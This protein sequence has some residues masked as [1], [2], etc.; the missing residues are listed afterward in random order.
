MRSGIALSVVLAA[1]VCVLLMIAGQSGPTQAQSKKLDPELVGRIFK[2]IAGDKDAIEIAEMPPLRGKE[3]M[4]LF[5]FENGITNG[6]LNQEQFLRYLEQLDELRKKTAKDPRKLAQ[7]VQAREERAAN[8]F[9]RLDLNSDNV[10]N[11][12]EIAKSKASF[13][14][15][16]DEWK[17]WDR[18][19]D[20]LIDMT[21]FKAFYLDF[22]K[23]R[24]DAREKA[25]AKDKD[26]KEPPARSILIEEDDIDPPVVYHYGKK[27]PP[28]LPKWFVEL[29]KNRDGQVS[30][31]EWR[32][33]GRDVAE[34]VKMDRND[35]GILTVEEVLWHARKPA[36]L[37]PTGPTRFE[38][39]IDATAGERYRDKRLFK[40]FPI[41]LE[42]GKTYQ[43]DL[44]SKDFDAYLYLENAAGALLAQ[45]D[46]SGG[47]LNARIVH[48]VT[49]SGA[50]RVIATSINGNKTG[51]FKLSIRVVGETGGGGAAKGV[52][53]WFKAL[54]KN[55]DGQVSLYEW[56]MGGRDVAEFALVDRND[57]GL[58]TAEEIL[59]YL[60]RPLEVGP[61][62]LAQLEGN[63]DE[64]REERYRNKKSFKVFTLRLEEGKTYQIDLISKSFQ[65]FIHLEDAEGNVIMEVGASNIGA[66]ARMLF[67]A[68]RTGTYKII[69][70]SLA[71]HRTGPFSLTIKER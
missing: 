8:L 19:G 43:I 22:H 62:G 26:K 58:I 53:P 71:G 16:H 59:L 60:K 56:R 33:G 17:K 66:N 54:D 14:T 44:V 68:D 31:Y 61:T 42:E 18:N 45:D 27:R 48:A 21:E 50:Y 15:F 23:R 35:D 47:N 57:D 69:A 51:A 3:E 9:R 49:R 6:Q 40:I 55:G 2:Q 38:G 32:M 64:S 39:T 7:E 28:G 52:P 34:F 29:D 36:E 4:E 63:V 41:R 37:S 20:G 5:A 67:E 65:A 25:A 12:D 13:G 30:L 10:L 70:T 1:L 11:A 24:D 46:D